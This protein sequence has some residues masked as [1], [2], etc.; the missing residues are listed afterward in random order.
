MNMPYD[1]WQYHLWTCRTIYDS[2]IYEH[3]FPCRSSIEHSYKIKRYSLIREPPL[4]QKNARNAFAS[5]VSHVV[6]MQGPNLCAPCFTVLCASSLTCR[7]SKDRSLHPA[8]SVHPEG[9]VPLL[10]H[11]NTLCIWSSAPSLH[12]D[13]RPLISSINYT[14]LCTIWCMVRYAVYCTYHNLQSHGVITILEDRNLP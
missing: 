12:L 14:G 3:A 10:V 4:L 8:V 1:L 11:I 2:T 9:L 7:S 6:R 13:I 5:N